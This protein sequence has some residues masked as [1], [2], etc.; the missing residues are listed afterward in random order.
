MRESFRRQPLPRC[1]SQFPT[2]CGEFLG[3]CSV[4]RRINHNGHVCMI[5]RGRTDHRRPADVDILDG[6]VEGAAG[7]RDRCFK[8]VEID[9]HDVD[10]SD[11]MFRHDFL[12]LLAARQ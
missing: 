7:F 8:R 10:L 4:V 1:R 5:L 6:L 12:V 3:Y 11:T 9:D 2:L